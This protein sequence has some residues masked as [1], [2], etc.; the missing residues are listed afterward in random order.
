M[1]VDPDGSEQKYG[2]CLPDVVLV[3]VVK[4]DITAY[5]DAAGSQAVP[6]DK[7]E[8]PGA[9]LALS[10]DNDGD[11]QLDYVDQMVAGVLL[12][13]CGPQSTLVIR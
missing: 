4:V 12:P 6:E 11:T 10:C 9:F 13:T 1:E 3:S 8:D 2:Y 7:E 5:R